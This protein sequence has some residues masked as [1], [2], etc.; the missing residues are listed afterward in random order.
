MPQQLK[1]SKLHTPLAHAQIPASHVAVTWHRVAQSPQWRGSVDVS[2]HFPSQQ[3]LPPPQLVP[4]G[5]VGWEQIPVAGS[6]VPATWQASRGA[7]GVAAEQRAAAWHVVPLQK[8][9]QQVVTVS[10]VHVAPF[11]WQPQTELPRASVTTT[12]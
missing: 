9:E 12:R 7:Q 8:P 4:S 3:T 1:P 2:T 11:G 6:H 10:G 5:A